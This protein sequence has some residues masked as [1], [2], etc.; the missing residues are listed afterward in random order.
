MKAKAFLAAF[1]LTFLGAFSTVQADGASVRIAGG[2]PAGEYI[3][4]AR[5]TCDTL[6]ALFSCN[7]MET[8]GSGENVDRL[9]APL[10]DPTAAD[11][12]FLKGHMAEAWQKESGFTDNYVFVRSIAGEAIF[13]VMKPETADAVRNWAG[14][15]EAAFL[16][17]LGLPGEKSGDAAVFKA[18]QAIDGSPLQALDVKYFK[19]KTELVAAVQAG[20][21]QIGWF[22]QYPNPDNALFKAIN[23]ASLVVMG[24]VDPDFLQL[25]GSFGVQDVV[26]AN[27]KA[28]GLGG[29]A[30]AIHTATIRAAILARAPKT[31]PNIRG[32]KVQEAA[33]ARI[34]RADEVDLLPRAPW[35]NSL[36]NS[37]T[38]TAAGKV[39]DM[40]SRLAGEAVGAKNRVEQ[41]GMVTK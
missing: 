29:A 23:D 19:G 4:F 12:T 30:K 37:T 22:V 21:I 36:I 18:L 39:G 40:Y 20:Q 35:I 26:I 15:K 17:S 11:V 33:I 8:K 28:F 1:G 31:Y 27:A 2:P 16:L 32:Q 14:V 6:G 3:T 24:V 41:L 5:Q 25:G 13:L 10:T 38:I 9:K 7:P 34:Q